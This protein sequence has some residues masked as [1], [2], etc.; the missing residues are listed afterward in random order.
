MREI[1]F[2]DFSSQGHHAPGFW[3]P[4]LCEAKRRVETLD[5]ELWVPADVANMALLAAR[6][7]AKGTPK[8]EVPKGFTG[9]TPLGVL[10]W[11]VKLISKSWQIHCAMLTPGSH[12]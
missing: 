1:I 9:F 10:F 7:A 4:V 3:A 8:S 11:N 5:M 2:P 6:V 12:G